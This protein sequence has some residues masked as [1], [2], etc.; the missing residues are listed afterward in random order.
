MLW[1]I[2]CHTHI[3]SGRRYIGLTKQT[4][5]KRWK[6]HVYAAKSS[7]GGK[8]HFPNAIRKYGAAAFSHEVLEVCGTLEE[9]NSAE[10]RWIEY[11]DT[12]NP[13]KG[14]NLTKGGGHTP[15]PFKNP[16]ER[17]EYRNKLCVIAKARWQDPNYR[18]KATAATRTKA[19]DPKFIAKCSASQKGKILSS[20]HRG[21][22]SANMKR[23]HA[24][25]SPE[26]RKALAMKANNGRKV[27]D[28]LRTTAERKKDFEKRSMI[29]KS[30]NTIAAVQTPEAIAKH[31]AKCSKLSESDIEEIMELREKGCTQFEI[32]KLFNIDRKTISYHERRLRK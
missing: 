11:F 6:N 27:R 16:W 32:A 10:E 7:K 25:K 5:Q 15:H 1:T 18:A 4:W 19:K 9:A 8:W 28:M 2:Y 23:L 24:S 30:L 14:F 3:E 20:D 26:E 22:I 29:S 31:R 17:P 12:R 21:K 13:E